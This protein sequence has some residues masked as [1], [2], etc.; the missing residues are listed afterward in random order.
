MSEKMMQ[1]ILARADALAL[2]MGVTGEALWTIL[3][4]QV[5]TESIAELV[6]S[7]IIPL[8]M[9]CVLRRTQRFYLENPPGDYDDSV[10]L[11]FAWFGLAAGNIIGVIL[12]QSGIMGLMN[13]EY[14][15]FRR[16]MGS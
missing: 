2:K 11:F 4:K 12:L 3:V 16:L 7:V 8:V 13:P 5:I 10:G 1:E 15:A 9:I 14:Y 6:M